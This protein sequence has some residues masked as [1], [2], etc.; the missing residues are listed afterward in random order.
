MPNFG[1]PNF[2][3]WM[4]KIWA[5]HWYRYQNL[6]NFEVSWGVKKVIWS[7]TFKGKSTY[8]YFFGLKGLY[9]TGILFSIS[10]PSTQWKWLWSKIFGR[11]SWPPVFHTKSG[12]STKLSEWFWQNY[13]LTH[14]SSALRNTSAGYWF[15]EVCLV[16]K[17][18]HDHDF[19]IR[20]ISN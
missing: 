17:L 20:W 7:W 11:P 5:I 13:N 6:K 4:R 10:L 8:F 19:S 14:N 2:R 15:Y 12:N 16:I 3:I 18:W 9:R 1:M